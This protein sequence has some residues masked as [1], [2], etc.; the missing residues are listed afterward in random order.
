MEIKIE[1]GELKKSSGDKE[2]TH[3]K[4][5]D[6]SFMNIWGNNMDKIGKRVHVNEPK[7]FKGTGWT[8]V[9]K[10]KPEPKQDRIAGKLT[11]REY[12]NELEEIWSISAKLESDPNAR[13]SIVNTYLSRLCEGKVIIEDEEPPDD[14]PED[15]PP[16]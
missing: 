5:I 4:L 11:K 9:D 2:Y 8:A 7:M 6:G 12:L 10:S 16:F 3:V 13:S 14:V 15:D 1:S